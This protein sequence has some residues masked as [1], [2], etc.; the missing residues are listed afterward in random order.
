VYP[1]R[2]ACVLPWSR[3]LQK[4]DFAHMT[5]AFGDACHAYPA[6]NHA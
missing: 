2:R 6:G 5:I 3:F 1:F 4:F